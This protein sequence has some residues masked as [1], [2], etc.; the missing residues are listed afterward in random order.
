ME[1]GLFT[2][3]SLMDPHVMEAVTGCR[4]ASR[5][6]R[7]ED[8]RA[9]LLSGECFPGLTARPGASSEG[10]LYAEIDPASWILLDRFEGD[11][12]QRHTLEVITETGPTLAWVYLLTPGFTHLLTIKPWDLAY[13]RPPH[14]ARYVAMCVRWRKGIR[15]GATE[16][17]L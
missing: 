2:F 12:Y 16:G 9:V 1:A 4:F 6:A 15:P 5:M 14:L 10:R 11:Y 17:T 8:H 7:L 13:F 3:G